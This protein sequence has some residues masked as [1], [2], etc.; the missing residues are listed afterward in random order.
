MG[1]TVIGWRQLPG[2]NSGNAISNI[3]EINVYKKASK[4]LMKKRNRAVK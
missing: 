1:A 4:Q 2:G 3:E